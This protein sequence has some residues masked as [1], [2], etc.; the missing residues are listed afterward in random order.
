MPGHFKRSHRY[1]SVVALDINFA[2]TPDFEVQPLG[3]RIDHRDT[4]SMKSAGNLVR[5]VVELASGVK[6]GQ[7][8]LRRR[9]AFFRHDLGGN[10]TSVVDNGCRVI[11]M[12]NNMDFRTETRQRFVN[13]IVDNF[14]NQVMQSIDSGRADVH[15]RTLPDGFQAFENFDMF[16]TVICF[17]SWWL[18]LAV[19]TGI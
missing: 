10:T 11:N 17:S 14:V 15:R 12:K 4:D 2:A 1:T 18:F 7:N 16:G 3:K 5:G 6:F 13:G 9:L 8:D 19:T